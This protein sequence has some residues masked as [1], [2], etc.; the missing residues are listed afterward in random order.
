MLHRLFR[1][2]D[3]VRAEAAAEAAAGTTPQIV[4]R[5]PVAPSVRLARRFHLASIVV[6]LVA[7]FFGT[8]LP[9]L[10]VVGAIPELTLLALATCGVAIDPSLTRSRFVSLAFTTVA[11]VVVIVAPWLAPIVLVAL[12]GSMAPRLHR[13]TLRLM[14]EHERARLLAGRPPSPRLIDD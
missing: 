5:P 2:I 13:L 10:V 11:I 3:R 14:K 1:D 4:S 8:A 7:A 12:V 9:I 6:A